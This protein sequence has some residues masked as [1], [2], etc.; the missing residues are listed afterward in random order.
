VS[1]VSESKRLTTLAR[2]DRDSKAALIDRLYRQHHGLVYRLALRYGQ[3]NEAWAEDVTHE[4]FITVLDRI[5][6][7]SDHD[8]L[9]GWLYRVTTN[10]CLGRM[11][12][13]R[14]RRA[15]LRGRLAVVDPADLDVERQ[16]DARAQLN[17]ASDALAGLPAKERVAFCMLHLD[18]KSQ[19]EIAEVLGHSKG[20]VSKLLKR[21]HDRLRETT[22]GKDGD[23]GD[24]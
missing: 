14:W 22:K 15:L 2:E 5:D 13:D 21:A 9:E 1:G 3:G 16:V 10:R 11:R 19:R 24:V 23:D 7:L 8:S 6:R 18:G 12:R 20:Y 4:V 17:R